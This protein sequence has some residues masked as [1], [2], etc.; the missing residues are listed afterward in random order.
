MQSQPSVLSTLW[1][2]DVVRLP[3][4]GSRRE[5]LAPGL[6]SVVEGN[7]LIPYI[8]TAS[9]IYVARILHAKRD[10]ENILPFEE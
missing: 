8:G 6:R 7:Y 9:G 10:L 3:K 4:V 1:N 5:D 2:L